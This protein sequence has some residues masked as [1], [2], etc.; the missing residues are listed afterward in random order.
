MKSPILVADHNLQ[1]SEMALEFLKLSQR[2]SVGHRVGHGTNRDSI[3]AN[4]VDAVDKHNDGNQ[5]QIH[6]L[7]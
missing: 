1:S 6:Q 3:D 7:G 5:K 2:N 4:G